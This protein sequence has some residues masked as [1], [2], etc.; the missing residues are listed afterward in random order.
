VAFFLKMNSRT[1]FIKAAIET[2]KIWSNRSEDPYK[3]VGVC[4]LNKDGRVLSVGYNGLLPKFKINRDFFCD[5]D[6][7][8]KY[9]IHAEIN[10]L[11]LIKKADEPYLLASTLLPCSNCATNI[12]A[13]GVKN[14]VYSE[15]YEKDSAAKEIFKFYNIELIKI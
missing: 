11:S 13:Y 15:E 7:R 1:S 2:A 10:A 4:I 9:M 8:R 5:R 6:N 12:V 14:V 3:K